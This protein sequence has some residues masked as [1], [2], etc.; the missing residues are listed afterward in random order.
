MA[1]KRAYFKLDVGYLMNPKVAAVAAQSPTAVL[2][3]VGSIAYAAQHLTDG[4]V[5]VA[6]VLRLTGASDADA[7]ALVDAGLWVRIDD[8]TIRVHDYTEHQR[9]SEQVKRAEE[10]G[11]RGATARWSATGIVEPDADRNADRMRIALGTA[12][13]VGMPREREREKEITTLSSPIADAIVDPP[14]TDVEAICTRMADRIE[15]NGSKR[16]T[17]TKAWRDAARLL[18][19]RDGHTEAQVLWLIDWATADTFWKA[20]I[21]SMP[22]FRDKF[23]QLRL[24]AQSETSNV[25]PIRPVVIDQWRMR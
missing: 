4:I 11:K 3:H 18:I 6:L 15:A 5:P 1:D 25:Q 13:E 12:S 23:D 22:K 10:A 8:H 16:P 7:D 20:N 17:I 14:R 24:K 19:D 2:L 21:L 9:S